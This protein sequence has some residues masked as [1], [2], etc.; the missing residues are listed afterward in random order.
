MSDMFN[1]GGFVKK[2]LKEREEKA[3]LNEQA[4]PSRKEAEKPT[5]TQAEFSY[6]PEGM[7]RQTKKKVP[8]ASMNP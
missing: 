3:G 7:T 8:P 6:G 4:Q 5:M 1:F 2:T